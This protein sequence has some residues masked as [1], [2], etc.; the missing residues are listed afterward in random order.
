MATMGQGTGN[1]RGRRRRALL[2]WLAAALVLAGL[3]GCGSAR[4]EGPLIVLFSDLGT[5]DYALARIK[6]DICGAYPQARLVDGAVSMPSFDVAAAAYILDLSSGPYPAG[7]VFAGFVNPG[8][9]AGTDCLVAVSK[10]GHVFVAPDN[11][12]LTRI[13]RDPGLTS[14]NRISAQALFSQPL[15]K[16]SADWVLAQAAALVA[17]GTAPQDLGPPATGIVTLDLPDARLI[18]GRV[19]GTV[20]FIDGF[21]NCLTNIPAAMAAELGLR[22]GASAAASWPKGHV[23]MKV[24]AAYGDVP[25]GDPLLLT[26]ESRQ[27][28]LCVNMGSF[29]ETYGIDTGTVV[30][31]APAGSRQSGRPAVLDAAQ[32]GVQ[33]ALDR[34]DADLAAAAAAL[35]TTGLDTAAARR[36]LQGL[37]AR[38]P[39]VVDF[40][41][42]SDTGTLLLVEPRTYEAA[43]GS[44]ISAQEQVIRLHKTLKPVLSKT[45]TAVEGFP[46]VDLEQPVLRADGSLAGSVGALFKPAV[47]L[48]DVI[49]RL[50]TGGRVDKVWV[51][52][53]DGLILYDPDAAQV[54][55]SLFLDPLYQPYKELLA[56][57]RKIAAQPSGSGSYEFLAKGSSTPIVK[58]ATWAS[59]GLHGTPWRLV[60][61][62]VGSDDGH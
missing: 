44:D 46:A 25:R 60:A 13:A 48:A 35:A 30:T 17:S 23:T 52:D 28:Q 32:R 15:E 34:L 55:T 11:G 39:E 61:A 36:V 38:H 53:T 10:R 27:L 50:P 40:S 31:L 4:K 7:T 29:A 18:D 1:N 41:T 19:T 42:V 37:A 58:D 12:M 51:M 5:A 21:G 43:Q 59:A 20:V 62:L 33:A 45:F 16:S 14:V 49:E 22:P 8:D 47:V 9:L 56:L 26:E 6:G 3:T 2:V 54:G 24:A 57:G